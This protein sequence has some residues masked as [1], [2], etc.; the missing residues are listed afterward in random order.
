MTTVLTPVIDDTAN[1]TTMTVARDWNS[2]VYQVLFSIYVPNLTPTDVVFLE[3]QFELSAGASGTF[4]SSISIG[5]YFTRTDSPT[6]TGG[7]NV[8]APAVSTV[9]SQMSSQVFVLPGVDTGMPAGNYYYNVVGYAV[10]ASPSAIP[11]V[12]VPIG[13]GDCSAIVFDN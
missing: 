9:L 10:G 5:R 12:Q 13:Y 4:Q 2:V 3:T 11:T 6:S 8:T 1:L 7:V